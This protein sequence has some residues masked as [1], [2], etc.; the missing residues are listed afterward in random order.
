VKRRR[1]IFFESSPPSVT[2]LTFSGDLAYPPINRGRFWG[3]FQRGVAE[4]QL[5]PE[6]VVVHFVADQNTRRCR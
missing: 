4:R 5:A 1:K 6:A 2:R 3:R